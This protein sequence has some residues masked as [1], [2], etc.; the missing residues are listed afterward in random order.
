MKDEKLDE[1]LREVR[2]PTGL[3]ASLMSIPDHSDV[4]VST[5]TTLSK[6]GA[7]LG[8]A[9]SVAAMVLVFLYSQPSDVAV[10]EKSDPETIGLL[11]AEMERNL[12]S[13]ELLQ[14]IHELEHQQKRIERAE[15]LLSVDES[16]ALAMTV[17][18]KSSLDHGGSVENVRNELEY[19][20]NTYPGT[21]G[22]REAEAILQIN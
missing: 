20:I 17:P 6:R 21:R 8:I 3:K 11:L 16:V 15:P 10:I 2:V 22:A 18:W 5:R 7:F 12:E 9:A 13:M 14:Q 19:V 1:L 4:Y